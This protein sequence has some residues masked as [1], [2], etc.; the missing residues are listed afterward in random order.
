MVYI[1]TMSS[2][3]SYFIKDYKISIIIN[4]RFFEGTTPSLTKALL[5]FSTYVLYL[6]LLFSNYI[7]ACDHV[8]SNGYKSKMIIM[9]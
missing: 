3:N 1:S 5:N 4:Y 7:S 8:Y 6:R 9:T 2:L